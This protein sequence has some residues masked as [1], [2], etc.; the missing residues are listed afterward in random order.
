M[1][2]YSFLKNI[3]FGD[4]GI[5]LEKEPQPNVQ[6]NTNEEQP[7]D[8]LNLQNEIVTRPIILEDKELKKRELFKKLFS[9]KMVL[10]G[11]GQFPE[12]M[13]LRHVVLL[14]ALRV[15][16]E[17]KKNSGKLKKQFF[18]AFIESFSDPKCKLKE[19]FQEI[20]ACLE[21]MGV[22]VEKH[23]ELFDFI[24]MLINS[25]CFRS[26]QYSLSNFINTQEKG[27]KEFILQQL[28]FLK[29]LFGPFRAWAKEVVKISQR[30]SLVNQQ[31]QVL[32]VER[33]GAKSPIIIDGDALGVYCDF[34]RSIKLFEKIF[35]S[36]HLNIELCFSDLQNNVEKN[37]SVE[38]FDK[39]KTDFENTL[40]FYFRLV[41]ELYEKTDEYVEQVTQLLPKQSLKTEKP[42]KKPFQKL[43]SIFSEINPEP[44][45]KDQNSMT[46]LS[47][48]QKNVNQ[49]D[50][51]FE[52]LFSQFDDINGIMS[53]IRKNASEI[54]KKAQENT[55]A[56]LKKKFQFSGKNSDQE[57][58]L[59]LE[60]IVEVFE[61]LRQK[62]HCALWILSTFRE[63]SAVLLESS[64]TQGREKDVD[65][66]KM[67]S[68]EIEQEERIQQRK[69]LRSQ[70]R[71]KSSTEVPT[72]KISEKSLKR[73]YSAPISGKFKFEK[74]EKL[75]KF[76][77]DDLGKIESQ[78]IQEFGLKPLENK[79]AHLQMMEAVRDAC[80]H[81]AIFAS[82]VDLW[83]ASGSLPEYLLF[84]M[85]RS[86]AMMTEQ[87]MTA[88]VIQK[89]GE[90]LLDHEH[91]KLLEDLPEFEKFR[92]L[93]G[94]L[95]N[96]SIYVRYPNQCI[97]AFSGEEGIPVGLQVLLGK[98]K[99]EDASEFVE[100][101][102]GFFD[103]SLNTYL[104]EKLPLLGKDQTLFLRLEISKKI[105]LQQSAIEL[106]I[107]KYEKEVEK[108]S[109]S[110]D[111]QGQRKAAMC[112]DIIL[113]LKG[114]SEALK[115]MEIF[116]QARFLFL[117]G[118]RILTHLQYMNELIRSYECFEQ[119]NISIRSHD[120]EFLENLSH[121]NVSEERKEMT[122]IR[123]LNT[124]YGAQYPHRRYG[125]IQGYN[126]TEE[127]MQSPVT[128]PASI[129]WRLN[130]RELM[131]FGDEIDM[132]MT[133][134]SHKKKTNNKSKFKDLYMNLM[135]WTDDILAIS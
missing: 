34:A 89:K 1:D 55:R 28:S 65:W 46:N 3:S 135:Q 27:S 56:E 96:G 130:A 83:R 126:R 57:C 24:R 120:L 58:D 42:V 131:V 49:I 36:E 123:D 30:L 134:N 22:D 6:N 11:W 5:F 32:R 23:E 54:R 25:E 66:K 129:L 40:I 17:A 13:P 86:A 113:H 21:K 118:D 132:E 93:L 91:L 19:K 105:K 107:K 77:V 106:R 52:K 90:I 67:F 76:S 70:A 50:G 45:E 44:L 4:Q 108:H 100:K 94:L 61:N 43:T 114:L 92:T 31:K 20:R 88:K 97:N 12:S 119:T 102:S 80:Y 111:H 73:D 2:P 62:L 69:K 74:K 53:E 133:H 47:V 26:E 85:I 84:P 71:W 78:S 103:N 75:A 117:H 82:C 39:A 41:K 51:I 95:N 98:C 125:S 116:P 112:K 122:T 15:Y 33:I 104:E 63:C 81:Q 60:E 87:W 18:A 9:P 124:I 128:V 110:K 64:A 37:C 10:L 7:N 8:E 35:C 101:L 115:A 16:S 59:F 127:G 109:F 79:R 38:S 68:E 14:E 72:E 99:F 29:T 48:L 121:P